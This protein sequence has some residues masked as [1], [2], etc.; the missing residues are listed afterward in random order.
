M[1]KEIERKFLVSGTP[2][3]NATEQY[4]YRQGY[5]S[6]DPQRV[7][8][9]RTD[10]EHGYLTIKGAPSGITRLEFEYKIPVPDAA[11]MLDTLCLKPLIEKTRYKIKY[12]NFVWEI[13]VF[14]GENAG[15]V[16]AEVELSDENTPIDLPDWVGQEV[17][18][19]PRYSNAALVQHPFS[20][21]SIL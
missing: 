21:W 2:W 19:D 20:T 14:E 5:L 17:T 4:H 16:I 15:L 18:G 8:R 7:I 3:H 6:L 13:D 9:I 1:A 11:E 10:G 12:H